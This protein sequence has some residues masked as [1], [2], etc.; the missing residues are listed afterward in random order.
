MLTAI[1]I[2]IG[3]QAGEGI[4]T[5]GLIL[6]KIFAR[7]GFS[8]FSYDE[9]PSLIRG[10]HNTYQMYAAPEPVY[11]QHQLVN[12]LVALD[13]QS[14]SEHQGELDK[15]SLILY[16]PNEFQPQKLISEK[17]IAVPWIDL[18]EKAGGSAIMANMVS[19]GAICGLTGLS[20]NP[21]FNLIADIFEKKGQDITKNNQKAAQA[22]YDFVLK[23]FAFH[24]IDLQ[25]PKKIEDKMV[26]TGN[27]MIG[28]GAV[29]AG[30]KYFA[31]YPMTPASNILH[32]LASLAKKY[33]II[34]NH[35]EN[36]ISAINTAIGAS[37]AGVRSMTATSG[38]GFSLM[39]EGLGLAGIS[40]TPL[41][42]V[43]GMRPGPASG[44]PTWTGQGDL[45]FMINASQDEF[46]RIVFTPGSIDECFSLTK[47]A[48]YLAEKYQLPV[49]VLVDKYLMESHKSCLFVKKIHKNQRLGFQTTIKGKYQRYKITAGGISPRP[50]LGQKGV[51]CLTNSYEHGEDGLA[52]EESE[53]R[54]KMT[55]K[56]MRKIKALKQELWAPKIFGNDKSKISLV[57]FGST[58]GPVLE[59]IKEVKDINYLHFDYVWPFPK[60]AVSNFL[61]KARKLVCLEGNASGQLAKLITQETGIIIENQ[62]LKYDG[63]PF[64]PEEIIDYLKK[65]KS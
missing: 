14:L 26:L 65:L 2:K 45:L 61:K 60:K 39:T 32:F 62:F 28:L 44:M 56:R 15:N 5:T 13:E 23:N 35:T 55:D 21:L 43:E 63:R 51:A 64:Y 6:S 20:L 53:V 30:L 1:N 46:P 27:E 3:G 8:I 31:A 7:S 42:I 17:F 48:F 33:S 58:L 24:K 38:G 16:D 9:Y 19:L 25:I 11:S 41:V 52:T 59:A 29:A 40:E 34:V 50:F 49:I 36:E 57:G 22:G 47:T 18:A 37:A 4:K 12:V 54:K 10:G